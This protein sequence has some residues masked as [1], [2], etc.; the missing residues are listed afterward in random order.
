MVGS[1]YHCGN[2]FLVAMVHFVLQKLK[3][4]VTGISCL[5]IGQG[6]HL[7]RH[8]PEMRTFGRR[9]SPNTPAHWA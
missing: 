9:R 1:A 8:L 5:A 7:Q 2:D 3:N 6:A 4:T